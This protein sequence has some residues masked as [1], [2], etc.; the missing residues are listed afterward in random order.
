[1]AKR[2]FQSSASAVI[3]PLDLDC[4]LTPLN[5]GTKEA[6]ESKAAVPKN[7]GSPPFA[8]WATRSS[9]LASSTAMADTNPIIANLPLILSGAGPL[10]AR[11]SEK[12]VLSCIMKLLVKK[13]MSNSLNS[14]MIAFKYSPCAWVSVKESALSA[15]AEA[16]QLR[17]GPSGGPAHTSKCELWC[18]GSLSVTSH[19]QATRA[20]RTG[21]RGGRNVERRT[22][23]M[24]AGGDVDRET[25]MGR[26]RRKPPERWRRSV[27]GF[28]RRKRCLLV[29]GG[30]TMQ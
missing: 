17:G 7:H 4:T 6:A 13:L 21:P 5:R 19:A 22:L 23:H 30:G 10:N 29:G 24:A 2:P 3:T 27:P 8:S 1:M 28:V 25:T 15:T 20:A 9:P 18:E 26:W 16:R 12:L 14:N 11:I